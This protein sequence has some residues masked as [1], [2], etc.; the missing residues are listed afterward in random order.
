VRI[1]YREVVRA[2]ALAAAMGV[3]VWG[4]RHHGRA[5]AKSPEVPITWPWLPG[6]ALSP[7]PTWRVEPFGRQ[8]T[9]DATVP[10]G[11]VL[12]ATPGVEGVAYGPPGHPFWAVPPTPERLLQGTARVQILVAGGHRYPYLRVLTMVATAYNGS[13]SMNGAWGAVSA[14]TGKPLEPG[15]VAVDP[16]VIPL[17]TH[18]YVQGYGPALADDTGSAIVGDRIDL[19]FAEPAA[20]VAH[21]GIRTVKV[22]V[23][24][25]TT[26]TSDSGGG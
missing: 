15:D 16:T 7:E 18:L 20:A 4:A 9:K 23:L 26:V 19:Y 25:T 22:Y 21:Y 10:K 12:V 24:A 17:G 13:P 11:L 2:M 14:W 6:G 8:V 3:T 5:T 1:R